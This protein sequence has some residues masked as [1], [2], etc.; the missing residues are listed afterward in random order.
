MVALGS[1]IADWQT[2]RRSRNE[3]F[4]PFSRTRNHY[5]AAAA[6]AKPGARVHDDRVPAVLHP[7]ERAVRHVVRPAVPHR[8]GAPDPAGDHDLDLHGDDHDVGAGGRQQEGVRVVHVLHNLPVHAGQPL[9]GR[10]HQAV[11]PGHV[12]DAGTRATSVRPPYAPVA[13]PS[14]GRRP[15]VLRR[16]HAPRHYVLPDA[17]R[18]RGASH[19]LR[20]AR[21]R[22]VHR[23]P[24][25]VAEH[26]NGLLVLPVRHEPGTSRL[27]PVTQGPAK[28]TVT[29][30]T[31]AQGSKSISLPGPPTN[32]FPR[33]RMADAGY[34]TSKCES[35][36]KISVVGIWSRTQ[37]LN[38]SPLAK[39]S[40][41][42][43]SSPKWVR[44]GRVQV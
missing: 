28:S 10:P 9:A 44:S 34:A 24:A 38:N 37:N 17:G 15:R 33:S 4:C 12:V 43:G 39:S 18:V 7:V 22:R 6:A 23:R 14:V 13:P 1:P 26:A 35:K 25:R 29:V 5:G 30:F 36:R 16:F 11:Q 42:V 3:C 32:T 19:R 8:D 20:A 40:G 27:A 31:T 2:R 21:R 41:F